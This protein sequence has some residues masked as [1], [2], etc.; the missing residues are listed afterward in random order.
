MSELLGRGETWQM[1]IPSKWVYLCACLTLPL[2]VARV[3][4][5]EDT[6]IRFLSGRDIDLHRT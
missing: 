6:V 3:D 5:P 1:R 2:G 4:R